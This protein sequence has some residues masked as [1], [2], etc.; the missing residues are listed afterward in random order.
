MFSRVRLSQRVGH[1]CGCRR[2]GV[3]AP[4]TG[5]QTPQWDIAQQDGG[6]RSGAPSACVPACL[7]EKV[8]IWSLDGFNT[9]H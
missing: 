7:A 1:G 6:S 3:R 9:S 2:V 4:Q 8:S 5:L